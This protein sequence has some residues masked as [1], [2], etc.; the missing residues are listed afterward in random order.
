MVWRRLCVLGPM[1]WLLAATQGAMAAELPPGSVVLLSEAESFGVVSGLAIVDRSD[2]SG[3]KV[4]ALSEDS[5]ALAVVKLAP[6]DYTFVLRLFAPAGDQDGFFVEV[7][8][9]RTRRTAPIG[10]WG[11]LAFPF[12]VTAPDPTTL[13]LIGQEPGM[14]A[15]RLAVVKGTVADEAVDLL[16]LQANKDWPALAISGVPR[17]KIPVRLREVPAAPFSAESATL[18]HETFDRVP[19]GVSGD[20]HTAPGKWGQ[21]LLLD[22]PDGRF[23]LDTQAVKW[24]PTGTIEWW[25]KPRPAQRLWH[26][27]GWHYFLYGLP[28]DPSGLR[29]DLSRHPATMLQLTVSAGT[30]KE[31]VQVDTGRA[32]LDE[33]H[34]LLVS[35]DLGGDTQY[36][37]LLFDGVGR[38][39]YFPRSLPLAGFKSL[40]LGNSPPDQ[41]LPY[42][43][44]DGG[45]DELRV[46]AEA[47]KGRLQ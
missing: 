12:R 14:L 15:D 36:L 33:W 7:N 41:D 27:Q 10:R 43:P 23:A 20:S 3:G 5:Q 38:C 25:V 34:H 30:V 32:N 31:T 29:F 2:G 24:G 4:A 21:G 18:V 17:L 6:G 37:W 46:S 16:K 9:V 11:N 35:W 19:S 13:S 39:S 8:G 26:D 45:L 40:G 28:G 22:A 44:M 42:L 1:L 47:V